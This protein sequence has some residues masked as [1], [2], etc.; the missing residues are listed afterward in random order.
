MS[1][2]TAL[3]DGLGRPR[4]LVIGDLILD[5]YSWGEAERISPEA[6]VPV[7]CADLHEARLGGAASVAGLLRALDAEVILAG[8]RGADS[9]GQLL[10]RL[11]EESDIDATA[12]L[13]D[14]LRPTSAKERFLGRAAGR[15]AQQLLRVDRESRV[16]LRTDTTARLVSLLAD[17]LQDVQ[18]VLV[19][20]Y[21]KGVCTPELL[22]AVRTATA[23]EGIPL[24]IDP[25]RQANCERYRGADL[26]K[27]NRTQAELATGGKILSPDD[28]LAVG[29]ALCRQLDLGATLVTLDRDG[30]VLTQAEGPGEWIPSR[31][32]SVF[33][34]TGA[35][36]MVLAVMGLCQAGDLSLPDAARLANVAAGLEVGQ[37]G[38]API[39]RTELRAAVAS[40]ASTRS[41]IVSP[42]DLGGLADACHRAGRSVVFTN[43]CFDLLHAGHVHCLEE[44]AD[45][46]DVLVVAI[47]TDRIVRFHK[48]MDRPVIA[49]EERMRMVGALECVDH[50]LLFDQETPHEVLRRLRPDVLVKGRPYQLEEVV[51]REIVLAYGGRVH[52][53]SPVEGVS[54]TQRVAALRNCHVHSESA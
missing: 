17:K 40:R 32:R 12:V 6:P 47:N 20:D 24:F 7:L 13:T 23:R 8:V 52:V 28:G 25:A 5:R 3:L 37:L 35:G 9:A 27:P 29:Q 26:L 19:S 11:L 38:V 43:G 21:G 50:V 42:G 51:G 2:L 45:L 1:D 15:H 46:G 53:T 31:A 36:D 10:T 14:H 48:G 39:T 54:T 22:T 49:Q 16:P 34:I 41:K 33:D 44:A 30:M 4:V 18:A